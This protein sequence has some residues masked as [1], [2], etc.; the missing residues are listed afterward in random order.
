MAEAM[1]WIGGW[2][3]N[4]ACWRGALEAR[5]PGRRHRFLDALGLRQSLGE[6]QRFPQQGF[7]PLTRFSGIIRHPY[8][9]PRFA[10]G[11]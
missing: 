8:D 10:G 7:N 1:L 4:L 6:R 2:A 9:M 11:A 3:S 5:Y